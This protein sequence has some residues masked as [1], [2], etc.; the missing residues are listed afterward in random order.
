MSFF[1]RKGT[2]CFNM[3]IGETERNLRELFQQ[4]KNAAPS[5]IFFDEMDGLCPARAEGRK[6]YLPIRYLRIFV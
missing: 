3:F 2:D 4:A 1:L 6:F 5:I